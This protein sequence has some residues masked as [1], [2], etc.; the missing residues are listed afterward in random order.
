MQQRA[1]AQEQAKHGCAAEGGLH[2][3]GQGKGGIA[4]GG[5]QSQ[6]AQLQAKSGCKAGGAVQCRAC[7][8]QGRC[9]SQLQLYS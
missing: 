7:L 2:G 5:G 6:V 9:P 4:G 8:K 3:T 1:G